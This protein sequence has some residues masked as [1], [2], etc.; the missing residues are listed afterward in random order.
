MHAWWYRPSAGVM[1]NEP[2]VLTDEAVHVQLRTENESRCELLKLITMH[3]ICGLQ[4][5]RQQDE[6]V[7]S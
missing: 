4:L 7:L 5:L 1:Y 2:V 6:K 3:I